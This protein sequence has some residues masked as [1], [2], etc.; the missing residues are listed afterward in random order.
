MECL[1]ACYYINCSRKLAAIALAEASQ[2]AP[3]LDDRCA[4]TQNPTEDHGGEGADSDLIIDR[5]VHWSRRES[6]TA[7]QPNT[8]QCR[9]D[10][11]SPTTVRPPMRWILG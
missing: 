4:L 8:V 1:L 6:L 2:R 11:A 5:N 9:S 10:R 7:N 3:V